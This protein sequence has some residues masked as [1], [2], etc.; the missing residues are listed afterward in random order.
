MAP[1]AESEWDDETRA[2]LEPL[3]V[4]G[5]VGNIFTTLVRHR[6]LFAAWYPFGLQLL[7][8]GRLEAR[9][10]ELLILRTA[11]N[12]AAPYEWGHHARI[13]ARAGITEPELRQI[14]EGPDAPGWSERDAALLR[15][16]DELHSDSRLSDAT[17]A[18]LA[19]RFDTE[20]LVEL[21]MLV[22][23]YTM[24]AY[25]LNSLGVRLEP[26]VRD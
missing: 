4:R 5:E 8:K 22:G 15:A 12:C 13:G 19:E 6:E 2:L 16:A 10:R 18:T 20:D 25:A 11:S 7:G 14:A 23:H 3:R 9:D 24:V 21:T 1:L 17:W 26:G